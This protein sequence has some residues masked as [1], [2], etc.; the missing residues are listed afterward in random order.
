LFLFVLAIIKQQVGFKGFIFFPL[1]F[2]FFFFIFCCNFLSLTP[3][4]VALT[5]Q[6]ILIFLLSFSLCSAVFLQGIFL[7]GVFFFRVFVPE[8]PL[9]LL[10][11]LIPIEIFSYGI[12]AL[13]MAIRLSANIIA[14]H[15]LVYIISS[16]LLLLL[17]F[18]FL[19][20]FFSIFSI[21]AVLVL[22]FG[23]AFL[24]AYVFTVLLS[25]YL[26]DSLYINLH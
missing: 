5:S 14:G 7:Q 25:I 12:R 19:L 9:L 8:S 6:I 1:V 16:F 10:F 2:N 3:F 4:A 18:H 13:S 26:H 15:T 24:Q 20:F 21:F 23:V 17:S 11:I 22:E